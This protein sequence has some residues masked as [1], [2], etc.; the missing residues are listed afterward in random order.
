MKKVEGLFCHL[1]TLL[2]LALDLTFGGN[3][4]AIPQPILLNEN[5][6]HNHNFPK[7]D[8][9]LLHQGQYWILN[10]GSSMKN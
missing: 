5:R 2:I 7:C 6:L 9:T 10:K 1:R 4:F 8:P 3:I